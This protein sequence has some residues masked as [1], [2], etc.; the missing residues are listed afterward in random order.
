MRRR[1]GLL[2][3]MDFLLGHSMLQVQQRHR[4]ASV[5]EAESLI[6]DEILQHGYGSWERNR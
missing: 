6:R 5:D 3:L 2:T 4:L 1:L